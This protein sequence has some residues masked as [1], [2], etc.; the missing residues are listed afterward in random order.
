MSNKA[1]LSLAGIKAQQ[2]LAAIMKKK[3]TTN[4]KYKTMQRLSRN[5]L[6]VTELEVTEEQQ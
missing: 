6:I 3:D 4:L 5:N 1:F 2:S